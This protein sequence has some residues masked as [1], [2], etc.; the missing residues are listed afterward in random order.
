[1]AKTLAELI[2]QA[3]A[4]Q[5]ANPQKHDVQLALITLVASPH[6][7]NWKAV[8]SPDKAAS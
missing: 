2:E 8:P 1:M 5:Q 3:R 4:A 7:A 6:W